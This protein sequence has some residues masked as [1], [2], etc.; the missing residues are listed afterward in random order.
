M[1]VAAAADRPS[2]LVWKE[3]AANE[4]AEVRRLRT[5]G[6]VLDLLIKVALDMERRYRVE[7][8]I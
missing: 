3:A 8:R 7:L 2:Y 6:K 4:T 1:A 5:A